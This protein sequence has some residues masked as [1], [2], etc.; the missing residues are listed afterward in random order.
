MCCHQNCVI[1]AGSGACV[2]STHLPPLG[3]GPTA[4][5]GAQH[6]E[7][8]AVLGCAW[9]RFPLGPLHSLFQLGIRF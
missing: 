2:M 4:P 8:S 6:G 1:K 7:G 5:V 3:A 9:P